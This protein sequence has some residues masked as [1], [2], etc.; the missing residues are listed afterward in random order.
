MHLFK[1]ALTPD[2][3]RTSDHRVA[4]THS[5]SFWGK[6]GNIFFFFCFLLKFVLS[7]LTKTHILI[8]RV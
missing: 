5:S 3:V 2:I 1:L 7:F 8:N 6:R 4:V